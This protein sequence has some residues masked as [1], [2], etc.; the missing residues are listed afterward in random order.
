MTKRSWHSKKSF[1]NWKFKKNVI[2]YSYL[3]RKNDV[4]QQPQRYVIRK[5]LIIHQLILIYIQINEISCQKS[6][7]S[8]IRPDLS[9]C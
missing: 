9:S 5:Y 1:D 6:D 8:I 4:T 2:L 7:C 3:C